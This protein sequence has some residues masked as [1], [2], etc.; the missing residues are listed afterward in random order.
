MILIVFLSISESRFK[1]LRE[2]LTA[3]LSYDMKHLKRSFDVLTISV[4]CYDAV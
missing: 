3:I 2:A 4:L 1:R